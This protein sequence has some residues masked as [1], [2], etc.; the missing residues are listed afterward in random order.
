MNYIFNKGQWFEKYY[1]NFA[2]HGSKFCEKI[3]LVAVLLTILHGRFA[4][5]ILN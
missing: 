2:I 1:L 5:E 3:R 4:I